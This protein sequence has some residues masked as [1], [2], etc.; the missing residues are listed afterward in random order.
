MVQERESQHNIQAES[1]DRPK[2]RPLTHGEFYL[3]MTER[4]GSQGLGLRPE[5]RSLFVGQERAYKQLYD[6][7]TQS[8]S[9]TVV[10][11]TAPFGAGKD[12]LFD[13]VVKDLMDQG[14]IKGEEAQR[15]HVD[16]GLEEGKTFEQ[17]KRGFS[18]VAPENPQSIRPKVLAV[19]E[20]AY[21]WG[22]SKESFQKQ[23]AIASK[24]LGKEVPIMVLLGDYALEDPEI[25]GAL[26]SPYEP[27]IIKLDPLTP[28]MLKEALIHRIAYAL[29]RSPKEID[30][31]TLI[32]SKILTPF[33][34]NTDH[35]VA[36][37]RNALVDFGSIGRRLSPTEETL[38]ITGELVRK[39]FS[40]EW[41]D[42]LWD[43]DSRKQ[44]FI[45]YLIQ[46]INNHDNGQTMMKA[47]TSEDMMQAC[48]LDI[49]PRR[50]K[51]RIV[52]DL[53]HSGI[54]QRVSA[55]PDLYLPR[56]EVFLMAA[57]RQLPLDVRSE[58]GQIELKR[59]EKDFE[60][61]VYQPR[62]QQPEGW[63]GIIK[64]IKLIYGW[65]NAFIGTLIQGAF[66]KYIK[67]SKEEYQ[68]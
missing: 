18:W 38:T 53:A 33:V 56:P 35:P 46:H 45:L 61:K 62:F 31:D 2:A 32:D 58:E 34:P 39:T 48:P 20:V 59:V 15:V 1:S 30:V 19:N 52:D 65:D 3:A 54:L 4:P 50:Y 16:F 47:M 51:S 12:A 26:G 43:K 17:T 29:E 28:D 42:R 63:A 68:G 13:V 60:H 9:G 8:P 25:V 41:Y 5:L 23:L 36:V 67:K 55:E 6:A 27:I 37:M 21:G 57:L 11:I 44:Q 40:K 66:E 10:A 22:H 49:D 7:I 64:R 14:K 24:F